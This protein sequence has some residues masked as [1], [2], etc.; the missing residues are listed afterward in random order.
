M[1][2]I[3]Y[4]Y[5]GIVF[6]WYDLQSTSKHI[7]SSIHAPEA[8]IRPWLKRGRELRRLTLTTANDVESVR[9]RGG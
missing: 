4:T 6:S 9:K 8:E 3:T 1:I 5:F 7:F 2:G